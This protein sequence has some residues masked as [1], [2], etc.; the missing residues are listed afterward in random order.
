MSIVYHFQPAISQRRQM[1]FAPL[2]FLRRA[3]C[4]IEL[5]KVGVGAIELT[6]DMIKVGKFR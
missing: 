3:Q 2:H 4:I 1:T 6:K 5:L